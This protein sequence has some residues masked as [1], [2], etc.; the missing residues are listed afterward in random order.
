MYFSY[1]YTTATK[2]IHGLASL[3]VFFDLMAFLSSVLFV[4]HS[5]LIG[6][7]YAMMDRWECFVGT[8]N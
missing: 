6:Y 2:R 7:V 8:R 1:V 5:S 3:F 4:E